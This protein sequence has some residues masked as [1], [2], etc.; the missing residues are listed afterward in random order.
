MTE[1]ITK[2]YSHSHSPDVIVK[3]ESGN[4]VAIVAIIVILLIALLL[5]LLWDG[6]IQ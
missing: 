1:E 2:T 6:I 4:S 5:A 3:E